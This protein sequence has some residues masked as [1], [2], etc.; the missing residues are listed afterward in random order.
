MWFRSSPGRLRKCARE[1]AILVTLDELEIFEE[2][3]PVSSSKRQKVKRRNKK[4][5]KGR[6]RRCGFSTLRCCSPITCL[7]FDL[8][9]SS[10]W[11]LQALIPLP[12]QNLL[13]KKGGDEHIPYHENVP[14][15]NRPRVVQNYESFL[16]LVDDE[17]D[18]VSG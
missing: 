18:L 9:A 8:Y 7:G 10:D 4:Y 14:T 5:L 6:R 12:N 13:K 16:P 15:S 1:E 17:L 11:L 2:N 3:I